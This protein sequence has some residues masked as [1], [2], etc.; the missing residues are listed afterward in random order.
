MAGSFILEIRCWLET[1]DNFT[2]WRYI[3]IIGDQFSISVSLSNFY[4]QLRKLPGHQLVR[5]NDVIKNLNY[6]LSSKQ[7]V[8]EYSAAF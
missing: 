7:I 3:D 8:S 5:Y 2:F 6:R 4:F 1:L